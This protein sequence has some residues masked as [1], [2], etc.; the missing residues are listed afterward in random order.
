MIEKLNLL[1]FLA[2][3]IAVVAVGSYV[4]VI[5]LPRFFEI[6]SRPYYIWKSKRLAAG[7]AD[8]LSAQLEAEGLCP[9]CAGHGVIILDGHA[10]AICPDCRGD[11]K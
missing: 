10:R 11:R 5:L 6:V 2:V 8:D 1:Q 7:L 3:W 4:G 9:T